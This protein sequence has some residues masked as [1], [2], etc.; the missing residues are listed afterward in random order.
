M[1]DLRELIP[2]DLFDEISKKPTC[3]LE[4]IGHSLYE[5]QCPELLGNFMMEL[6]KSHNGE[7]FMIRKDRE[8]IGDYGHHW[9][10]YWYKCNDVA[11]LISLLDQ[12]VNQ[13]GQECLI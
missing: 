11:V 8:P 2:E 6:F 4:P 1:L 3:E 12:K 7:Y 5:S 9:I 10:D 13:G